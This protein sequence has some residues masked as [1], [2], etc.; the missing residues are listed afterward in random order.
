MLES[1]VGIS[2][3]AAAA[4][5]SVALRPV[6]YAAHAGGLAANSAAPARSAGKKK[7]AACRGFFRHRT[8]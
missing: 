8:R 5:A 6:A 3:L 2:F 7:A 1:L 4:G